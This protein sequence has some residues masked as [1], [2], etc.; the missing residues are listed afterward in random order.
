MNI[1]G[2]AKEGRREVR[3]G[4]WKN[5]DEIRRK[6]NLGKVEKNSRLVLI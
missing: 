5:P 6:K 3:K 4:G 1:N 2:A